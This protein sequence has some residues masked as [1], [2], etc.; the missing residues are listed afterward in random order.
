MQ[1]IS[2]QQQK[3]SQSAVHA[4]CPI[5]GHAGSIAVPTL[6]PWLHVVPSSQTHNFAYKQ[7]LEVLT[8]RLMLLCCVQARDCMAKEGYAGAAGISVPRWSIGE[9]S[10]K[11]TIESSAVSAVIAFMQESNATLAVI[12]NAA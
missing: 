2:M 1:Q 5:S 11:F 3:G 7:V 12:Q 10:A 8:V 9:M 4:R 6:L